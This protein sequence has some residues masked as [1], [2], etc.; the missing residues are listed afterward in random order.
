MV[1]I[2][3][4]PAKWLRAGAVLSPDFWMMKNPV[5]DTMT[6][7]TYTRYGFIPVFDTIRGM[8]HLVKKSEQYHLWRASGGE[9]SMLVSID[10]D[11]LAKTFREVLHGKDKVDY[12]KHPLEALQIFAEYTESGTRLAEFTT[13]L[14]K[15]DHPLSASIAS[16]EVTLD[17]AVMGEKMRAMNHMI[18]FF[19]SNMRAMDMLGRQAIF[20]P[21]KFWP[22]VLLGI[23]MPSIILWMINKDDP[24][25][26]ELPQWEKDL[27]WII[28][29]GDKII[30]IPKP[31]ELGIL[32]GSIPERVL[33]E[34]Y[35]HDKGAI[36]ESVWNLVQ[37]VNPGFMP[38]ALTPVV[39]N[40][41]NYN[42]FLDRM[43]TPAGQKDYP[44]QYQYSVY[45]PEILKAMGS[46]MGYSP[47]KLQ[48]LLRGY[49][50]GLG[51][52]VVEGLN[53]SL[54]GVGLL[55]H[56]TAPTPGLADYPITKAL[57]ARNPYGSGSASVNKFY[58]EYT[59]LKEG[60]NHLKLALEHNEDAEYRSFL[61]AHPELMFMF[62]P[63]TGKFR[64]FA[65]KVLD[66]NARDM[67]RIRAE[68]RD[69]YTNIDMTAAEKRQFI[70]E[71]DVLLTNTAKLAL[72]HLEKMPAEFHEE[73]L[74]EVDPGKKELYNAMDTAPKY[75]SD[76]LW[77][78]QDKFDEA[79]IAATEQKL[80]VKLLA[81]NELVDGYDAYCAGEPTKFRNAYRAKHPEIDAALNLTGRATTVKSEAAM[82]YLRRWANELGISMEAFPVI[83]KR[84]TGTTSSGPSKAPWEVLK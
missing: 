13:G 83:I 29:A 28:F 71:T 1:Q 65:V 56:V 84:T 15:G 27:F 79:T 81:A 77:K 42:F 53:K 17:F 32:F 82:N 18:A 46:K 36:K 49:T 70:D 58:N 5:R 50:G 26:R 62:D 35:L 45:T 22:R 16:R 40:F 10:R 72:E 8:F 21:K 33:D 3:S 2:L 31:F 80:Y 44:A 41:A 75:L 47:R 51:S 12:V 30:R 39:E 34:I 11:Y 69:V 54:Q 7:Y 38:T 9:R 14:K 67:A 20:N 52:Y 25:W 66:E 55:P 59:K 61:A 63:E 48:N 24:R 76:Y 73:G 4:Q 6:A 60:E 43:I 57:F 64:S 37:S 23:T 74:T 19:N 78:N 68:Q